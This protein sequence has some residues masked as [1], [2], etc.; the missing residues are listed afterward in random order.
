MNGRELKKACEAVSAR[1]LEEMKAVTDAREAPGPSAEFMAKLE[2]I[3]ETVTAAKRRRIR[4]RRALLVAAAVALLAIGFAVLTVGSQKNVGHHLEYNEQDKTV[5]IVADGGDRFVWIIGKKPASLP[6]G[7]KKLSRRT[8]HYGVEMTY[9]NGDGKYL[10]YSV[11][12]IYGSYSMDVENNEFTTVTGDE[13]TYYYQRSKHTDTRTLTEVRGELIISVHTDD[14]EL[15]F[16][17]L[18]RILDGDF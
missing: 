3:F 15:D 16:D 11:G 7:Y 17:D 2:D 1:R 14:T 8:S 9:R 12:G 4:V 18:R 6:D 5:E 13:A 10:Y